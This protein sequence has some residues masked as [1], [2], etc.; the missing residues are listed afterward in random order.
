[1]EALP[2]PSIQELPHDENLKQRLERHNINAEWFNQYGVP[3]LKAHRGKF[4]AVSKGTVF[5]GDSRAEVERLARTVQPD[6]EPFV[7]YIPPDDQICQYWAV[8]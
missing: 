2:M 1:M 3:F 6:D 7:K 8:T 5:V 4:I